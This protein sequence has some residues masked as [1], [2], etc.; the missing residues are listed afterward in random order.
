MHPDGRPG[1]QQD[2]RPFGG[3]I[4]GRFGVDLLKHGDHIAPLQ[5][6][7]NLAIQRGLSSHV[8]VLLGGHGLTGF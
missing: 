1:R 3:F 8:H 6:R 7:D 5:V 2:F 4:G